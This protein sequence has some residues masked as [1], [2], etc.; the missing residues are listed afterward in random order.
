MHWPRDPVTDFKLRS[1]CPT[2]SHLVWCIRKF[3][4]IRLAGGFV[5]DV[6]ASALQEAE[7]SHDNAIGFVAGPPPMVDGAIRVLLT[8][9]GLTPDRIRYDK[10]S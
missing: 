2:R 5:H 8:G 9:A 6:A 10:F 3:S 1:H 4:S 7:T